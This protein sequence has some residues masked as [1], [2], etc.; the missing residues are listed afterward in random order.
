MTEFC[1]I[2]CS[3]CYL[4]H[5]SSNKKI[6]KLI[7]TASLERVFESDAQDRPFTLVFHA[8]EPLT[9]PIDLFKHA[10]DEAR[11]LSNDRVFVNLNVQTNATLINNDW[12]DFFIENN[13]KVGVSIDGP[14]F[15]TDLHRKYRSGAGAYGPAFSGIELLKE[16]GIPFHIIAVLTNKSLSFS[17]EIYSFF[18]S[19]AP[20]AVGFNIDEQDGIN[21][22]SSIY[23]CDEGQYRKFWRK[24]FQIWIED[25]RSLEIREFKGILD[26]VAHG[27][28]SEDFINSNQTNRAFS[29]VTVN[30]DGGISTFSPELIA[31]DEGQ[32]FVYGNVLTDSFEDIVKNPK[33][34]EDRLQINRG[35]TACRDSCEYFFFCGGG[36]PSNKIAENG[37]FESTETEYCRFGK[38][39]IVDEIMKAVE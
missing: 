24:L 35:V 7:I 21:K 8:G 29:I 3:Y 14:Q 6:T 26:L 28:Q 1:N 19:M 18:K 33:F 38:M 32:S 39:I 12:C 15:I 20:T 16:R 27:E 31:V 25:D 10:A 34:L 17:D 4:P 22:D 37:S 9:A 36:S 11:R 5:R 23:A 13:V 30:T 2:D